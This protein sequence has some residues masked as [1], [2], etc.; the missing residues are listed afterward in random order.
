[1]VACE[2][3]GQCKAQRAVWASALIA[4][5]WWLSH[6]GER[7]QLVA[8][9]H[10]GPLHGTWG[11]GW[12]GARACALSALAARSVSRV[13]HLPSAQCA[14]L[15]VLA[16][17]AGEQRVG[18]NRSQSRTGCR[19]ADVR[20]RLPGSCRSATHTTSHDVQIRTAPGSAAWHVEATDRFTADTWPCR[21]LRRQ[22]GARARWLADRERCTT[23]ISSRWS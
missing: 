9:A 3:V 2:A 8:S 21:L 1:M 18:L 13:R 15:A 16:T 14:Q 12:L 11:W 5:P 19:S 20:T 22:R 4:G 23:T 6:C 17:W 7:V 10:G